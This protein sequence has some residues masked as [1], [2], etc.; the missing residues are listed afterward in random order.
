MGTVNKGIAEPSVSW[1]EQFLLAILAGAH[2]RGDKHG[3]LAALRRWED[4]EAHIAYRRQDRSF[5]PR[6]FCVGRLFC[7]NM[8]KES[9]DLASLPFHLDNDTFRRIQN[10]PEQAQLLSKIVH[11]RPEADSLH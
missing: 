7:L 10:Y 4:P 5:Y 11:C 9:V 2:I 3:F 6:Y 1:I 8:L